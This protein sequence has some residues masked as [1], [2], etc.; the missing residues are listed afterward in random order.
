MRRIER[1]KWGCRESGV[2]RRRHFMMHTERA[3]EANDKAE[4]QAT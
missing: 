1:K 2:G 3:R 4:K